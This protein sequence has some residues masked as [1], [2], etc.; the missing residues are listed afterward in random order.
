M[1]TQNMRSK[2]D[3]APTYLLVF[4]NVPGL[5]IDLRC[6]T[7][8]SKERLLHQNSQITA[9][10]RILRNDPA[11]TNENIPANCD[12]AR[13]TQYVNP[14]ICKGLKCSKQVNTVSTIMKL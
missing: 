4:S 5:L 2:R 13:R 7:P 1:Y 8:K 11:H 14:K 9:Q 12:P 10:K 3:H 6:S